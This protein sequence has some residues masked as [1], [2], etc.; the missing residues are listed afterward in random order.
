LAAA[1]GAHPSGPRPFGRFYLQELIADH[2]RHF[3]EYHVQHGLRDDFTDVSTDEDV[4]IIS[5]CIVISV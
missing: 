1:A 5:L 4:S 2:S 3:G